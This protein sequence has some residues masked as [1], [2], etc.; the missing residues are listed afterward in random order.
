MSDGWEFVAKS[1]E[2][3]QWTLLRM[4][5]DGGFLYSKLTWGDHDEFC[6]ETMAF[7]PSSGEST[8]HSM[9]FGDAISTLKR[10]AKVCRASW[11]PRRFWIELRQAPHET[12]RFFIVDQHGAKPWSP[13][14][15]DLL[16]ED[17]VEYPTESEP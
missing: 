9:P 14:H 13:S 1:H 5:V 12:P 10:G 3:R 17:W 8:S 11:V 4:P 6:G 15:L 2:G 16:A 7:V